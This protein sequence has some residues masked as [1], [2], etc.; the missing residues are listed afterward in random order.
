MRE[1]GTVL[2]PGALRLHLFSIAVRTYLQDTGDTDTQQTSE[3]FPMSL[4]CLNMCRSA[5]LGVFSCF[6]GPELAMI[7]IL[8]TARWGHM[9]YL[10]T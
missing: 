9:E 7:P 4:P 8:I 10:Y 6:I 5:V 3:A 2:G 1:C